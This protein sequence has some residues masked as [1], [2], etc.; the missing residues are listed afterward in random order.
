[1]KKIALITGASSGIGLDAAKMLADV[2]YIVY[3][4]A[5]RTEP[6]EGL[7]NPQIHSLRMDLTDDSSVDSGVAELLLKE[8]RID[9]LVNNAGYGSFGP[10]EEV[11]LEEAERQLQVNVMGA[12]RISKAV[13]PV[14]RNQGEG[15]I[16]NTSSVA[17]RATIHFGGW[18]NA[19]KYA[20]EALSDALR[21]ELKPYGISVILIEPGGIKT[22]WGIIA[23]D[24]LS[25]T[26]AGTVYQNR[27]DRL[28]AIM[29]KGYSGRFLS[30]PAV[31]ARTILKAATSRSPKARY[32]CGRGAHLI[33]L[34]HS[35]LPTRIFD[36]LLAKLT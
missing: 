15:R 5:R 20:L 31:V 34:L 28:A 33:V 26:S 21:M 32:L 30:R 12:M 9:L 1:M 11:S 14:M 7:Q 29:R 3:G 18:Y 19:S 23:A 17:G 6:I 13:I 35:I 24:K 36:W 2:G 4:A 25:E 22:D 10:L 8:G 16:I 27:A